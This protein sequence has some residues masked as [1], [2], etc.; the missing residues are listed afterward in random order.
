MMRKL[1]LFS[2]FYLYTSLLNAQIYGNEWINYNQ[3]YYAFSI[4]HEGIYKLDYT[5]LNAAGIPLASFQSA[6]IQIFGRE[7][8][9]PIIVFDGN[10]NTLDPGDYVLFYADRNDG[11]LDKTLYDD[12]N[13]QGNPAYSL[14]NDTIQYFFTWNNSTTNKR[15]Q[16]ETA[17]DF[18]NYTP[19]NFVLSTLETYFSNAY[20]V[21]KKE[22]NVA[23]SFYM[24]GEGW[25]TSPVNGVGGYLQNYSIPTVS[26]YTGVDAPNSIF[27]AVSV[28]NSDFQGNSVPIDHHLKMTIGPSNFQLIDTLFGG[29]TSIP[30]NKQLPTNNLFEGNTVLKWNIVGDLPSYITVDYQSLNYFSLQYPKIPHL[31]NLNKGKFEVINASTAAKVRLDF[32]GFNGVKPYLIVLGDEPKWVVPEQN[33]TEFKCLIP[34]STFNTNQ[35]LWVQD[36]AS[37]VQIPALF[38]VNSTGSFTNF[39]AGNLDS[40]LIMIYPK[41]LESSAITYKNYRASMAGGAHNVVFANA[42]ELYQQFGGGIHKHINGLR[43]FSYFVYKNSSKK[44]EGLFLIGKGIREADVFSTVSTGPGTRKNPANFAMSLLPSFGEPSSD[45]LITSNFPETTRIIPLIPTGRISVNSNQELLDYLD[46]VMLYDANQLQNDVYNTPNKDWQKQVVH[47]LGGSD[48]SQQSQIGYFCNQMR[49]TIESTKFGGHVTTIAK[50]NSDPLNPSELSQVMDRITNG[51]SLMQFFGHASATSSGF[52]INIDEPQNWGNYGKYPI[53]LV[54]SC[55][56]GNIFQNAPSKS[57]QFVL[58]KDYGAIAYIGSIEVGYIHSL[59]HFST[60]FYRNLSRIKYGSTLAANISQTISDLYFYTDDIH[61]A[62]FTQMTLHGDPMIKLNWHEKPEIEITESSVSFSPSDINLTVD[63]IRLNLVITN[64]GQSITSPINVEIKRNFPSS[65]VDSTYILSIPRLDYKDTLRFKMP[66]QANISVGLNQFSIKVDLPNFY[67]EQYDEISNNQ[68]VKNLFINIDGIQPVLPFEF[69][70]VPRDT[71]TVKASTINPIA[72]WNTYRFEIDT[73]DLFNS[74]M[75]RYALVSGYGGVKEVHYNQWMQNGTNSPLVCEDSMVYFWRVA[76][77]EPNP[78]WRESSF[79][80]IVNREGWG[81]DHFFQFKKNGFNG[82]EYDRTNRQKLFDPVLK[83]LECNVIATSALPAAYY[84]NWLIDGEQQDYSF[85]TYQPYFC[86]GV[87]DPVTFESWGTRF[88]NENPNH[89]FGNFNDNV[90]WVFKYFSFYQDDATSL[91]AF[92]NMLLNE[93]PDS[94]YVIVFTPVTARFDLWQTTDPSVFTMFA[95]LGSDSIVPGHVN[96][97]FAFFFKKGDPNSVVEEIGQAPGEDVYLKA[98]MNGRDYS[99]IETSTLIG[100]ASSWGNVY[101][102]QDPYEAVNADTTRL[103]IKA[104]DLGGNFISQIDTLFTANDSLMNLNNFVDANQMPYLKL[105][106]YYQDSLGFTPAQM[107]RWHVLY[108]PLPEAAIDGSNPYTFLPADTLMEGQDV[109]FA[110]DIKNIFHLDMDSLLVRYWIEDAQ[111]QVHPIAYPRQDSLLVGGVLRDTIHFNTLGLSGIN[112]L[113]VEVNPYVNGSLFITD[114]PEQQHFN[115]LLQ[116]PFF[117]NSD[118]IHPILDVTFDGR[119]ILNGDIVSP[120][121]EIVI[122]LK[123]DNPYLIMNDVSDTTLFGIYLTGPDGIQKRIPFIDAQG[124][125]VMQWIPADSGNKKFK[126]IYPSYFTQ[127][128]KYTLFVQGS[129]RSGNVSGDLDYKISFE[130]IRESSISYMMNYPNPFSTSTRFVFT[131]TGTEVPD[132]LI[133]QIMTVSGKVVREITED[134]IGPIQIGRNITQYAWD[135]RDE[136]GDQLANGVYLYTVKAQIN[137]ESIKHRETGAD[138]Y[139]KKEFG[140][141]YLLR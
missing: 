26:I 108:Q 15:F 32:A 71:V 82:I 10:D 38:S 30:L 40:A 124:A 16:V 117:V 110:V 69:A 99:G 67:D 141:M 100:P 78:N 135:G 8:E 55:Y 131:L 12:P 41:V 139:F 18:S 121:S 85:L 109:T 35:K 64:L 33:T 89:N 50:I 37:I 95:A 34:N 9:I 31:N 53:M 119:H 81:Q 133:I 103:R 90:N 54:N 130:V 101:W 39:L 36:S 115:N 73:T 22:N 3:K 79:Q 2:C 7:Q 59:G 28:S 120:E 11:W 29:Y 123:D 94:S 93:I 125:S 118:D 76:V 57:E 45:V 111:N 52:E 132:E 62:T 112:S 24:Q 70:V 20:N 126:I 72:D 137:G 66:L 4:V 21:G 5:T 46:K 56:N 51:V 49:D 98:F 116:V 6:N 63:S 83:T 92:Q 25:G 47:F 106:A 104:Y 84:N 80:Y 88:G 27:K 105:E 75:L 48:A 140:K 14:Y 58:V 61:E 129:D 1:L 43:R 127:D 96:R 44:P 134:Q 86:V 77:D 97:P 13:W 91:A 60:Q 68:L 128:G 42:E 113:W 65:T 136:F 102:K 19:S 114:Q 107:D 23:S 17:N 74:P 87:V 122:T 138:T